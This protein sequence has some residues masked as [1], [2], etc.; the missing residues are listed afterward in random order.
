MSN[1]SKPEI[2]W[3]DFT[4]MPKTLKFTKHPHVD[5]IEHSEPFLVIDTEHGE[6]EAIITRYKAG[7]NAPH[8]KL[9]KGAIEIAT[10]EGLALNNIEKFSL[11]K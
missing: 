8:K 3:K 7:M 9:K 5:H 6:Q 1:E 11:L 10:V 4:S 2:K